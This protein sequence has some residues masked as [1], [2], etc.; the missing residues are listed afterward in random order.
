MALDASQQPTPTLLLILDGWGLGLKGESNAIHMAH[1][2]NL[3]RIQAAY[4]GSRLQCTGEAVGLPAG[5]MGNSEVGH[6]NIGAGRIVDQDIVRIDKAI[7]EGSLFA[8]PTL[9][10]LLESV[11]ERGSRLHLMGLVSDGGVHSHI[12]HLFAL[13]EMARGKS[14]PEVAVHAFLDG[15]DTSPRSGAGYVRSLEQKMEQL[16]I[17]RIGSLSGRYYAMDRDK[18]W[19]R[20]ALAYEAIVHGRGDKVFDP[21]QAVEASYEQGVTDEFLTPKVVCD[22]SGQPVAPVGDGDGVFWFNFRADRAKQLVRSLFEQQFEPFDRGKAPQL[23]RLATMNQYDADFPLPVAFPPVEL[24]NILGEVCAQQGLRQLRIAETEKYA[25]VTYFFNGGREEPFPGED[26]CLIPSPQEVATYDQKPE[27]SLQEVIQELEKR[28]RSQEH[29]LVVCNFANLD[30]V[31]HTGDFQAAVR[32][33]EA[34]D[35]GLGRV[36]ACLEQVPGRLLVTADHGNADV[37]LD[38]RQQTQT[39]HSHN[40]VGLVWIEPE[41]DSRS[42]RPEGILGDVAPTIL[43]LWGLKQP[44]EMTGRSLVQE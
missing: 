25:H 34:V 16:G 15:R 30:M 18:R 12:N 39:A 21:V 7:R 40:P 44:A 38:S 17:G 41:K 14:V 31:G 4:P 6:L 8:N 2:P 33:C 27:M 20:T 32:A 9:S 1:T 28:W 3:D 42:L 11:R 37:M 13:L 36:L 43:H 19:D 26:R 23:C 29:H 22:S 35:Q 5:Q 24:V 10:E